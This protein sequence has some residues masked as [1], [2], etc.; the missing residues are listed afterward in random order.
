M[1]ASSLP[2]V[3]YQ[4]RDAAV[5]FIKEQLGANANALAGVLVPMAEI[6][7]HAIQDGALAIKKANDDA[8]KV[9]P[10]SFQALANVKTGEVVTQL[11]DRLRDPNRAR[12]VLDSLK[13]LLSGWVKEWGPTLGPQLLKLLTGLLGGVA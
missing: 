10:A 8:G 12:P 4:L 7:A 13:D 3:F 11:F 9:Q 1:R 2:N 5:A 6:L